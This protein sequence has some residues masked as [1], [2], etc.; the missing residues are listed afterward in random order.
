MR[1]KDRVARIEAKLGLRA[2]G[3]FEEATRDEN[4][5][6]MRLAELGRKIDSI[7]AELK[8]TPETEEISMGDLLS[9]QGFSLLA[10]RF[11]RST[12]KDRL[13]QL[14]SENRMLKEYLGIEVHT[15]TE[16]TFMRKRPAPKKARKSE[17]DDE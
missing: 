12:V 13:L 15:E 5:V 1:T 7:E 8:A 11:R 3:S 10:R 6:L 14:E 2:D 17:E 9:S 16:R 4:S